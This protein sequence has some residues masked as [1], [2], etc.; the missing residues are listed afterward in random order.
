MADEII[1]YGSSW[2]G[3]TTHALKTLDK[4]GVAYRYIEVDDS[5]EDE[6]RI[7]AWNNGRSIRPTIDM[8]G[9]IFVNPDDITLFHA[10]KDRG[11]L[12]SSRSASGA[13]STE[14]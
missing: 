9:D 6:Q 10:L 12:M 14:G 4:L 7:A 8:H 3:Y 1:V 2:C 5:P 11:L 13:N